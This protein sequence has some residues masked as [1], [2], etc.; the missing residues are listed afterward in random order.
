MN[1]SETKVRDLFVAGGTLEADHPTYV[2]R[3]ADAQLYQLAKAGKFA[4]VLT[5]RQ[6]GK[7]S[8]MN[9]IAHRLKGESIRTA[10]IDLNSFGTVTEETWYIQL[11]TEL[12]RQLHLNEFDPSAWWS[13][14]AQLGPVQQFN[15]FL[16]DIVLNQISEQVVVFIDEIDHTLKL[17]NFTD[18]F[19]SAI[20][21]VYNRRAVEPL[22]KRLN[23]ILLGTASPSE[24][25]ADTKQTPFNI[26]EAVVLQ[27]FRTDEAR[28][29]QT[30]LGLHLP[31]QSKEI[32]DRVYYWTD[33]HPYLTQKLCQ[34]ITKSSN[35]EWTNESV[36]ELV[37]NLFL[38][39]TAQSESNL[40]DVR[41]RI[42]KNSHFR[43][44]L[45]IYREVYDER[46]V[47]EKKQSV[48]QNQLKLSGLVKTQG[49]YLK[50][51]N[52]I[53]HHVFD[54][55]WIK[56]NVQI[57]WPQVSAFL[58]AIIALLAVS[59]I[60]Y[61]TWISNRI[62]RSVNRLYD[63][64]SP[65]EQKVA[66]LATLFR[67]RQLI[68]Q[69]K[70]DDKALELLYGRTRDELLEI[71]DHPDMKNRADLLIVIKGISGTLADVDESGHT[72]EVLNTIRLSLSH[73]QNSEQAHKKQPPF[74]Q[75]F[76]Y[77]YDEVKTLNDI[78]IEIQ[79]W[80]DGRQLARE[81]RF[82]EAQEAYN[83]AIDINPNNS[84]TRYERARILIQLNQYDDVLNDLDRVVTMARS[85]PT[86]T[87]LPEHTPTS[88]ATPEASKSAISNNSL[89]QTSTSV[90]SPTVIANSTPT[91]TNT[92]N[93]VDKLAT[94]VAK[95]TITVPSRFTAVATSTPTPTPTFTSI[96]APTST[97]TSAPTSTPTPDTFHTG[98]VTVNEKIRAA[99]ELIQIDSDLIIYFQNSQSESYP[100]LASAIIIPTAA[101]SVASSQDGLPPSSMPFGDLLSESFDSQTIVAKR[102]EIVVLSIASMLSW[103]GYSEALSSVNNSHP[104]IETENITPDIVD[105]L[106]SGFQS[107]EEII[108]DSSTQLQQSSEAPK[109][110]PNSAGILPKIEKVKTG[111]LYLQQLAIRSPQVEALEAAR[112]LLSEG[113]IL[114]KSQR[115]DDARAKWAEAAMKFKEAENS[116]GRAD[117]YL[118]IADS[119]QTEAIFNTKKLEE[120]LGYYLLATTSAT[121]SYESII[122]RELPFDAD[123]LKQATET[124][125]EGERLR[126]A[127]N[128]TQ[129][130]RKLEEARRLF[131]QIEFG[132]GEARS[133]AF[134]AVCQIDNDDFF[135]GLTT[136]LDALLITQNLPLGSS[137]MERFLEGKRAYQRGN[138]TEA[139][140]IFTEILD[141]YQQMGREDIAAQVM[142][143]MGVAYAELGRFAEAKK[144]FETALPIF[145]E[146]ENDYD[147][148]NEAVTRHNLANFATIEGAFDVAAI[149][150][151]KAIQLWWFVGE[152]SH[153]VHSLSGL[154]L[155]YTGQAQYQAAFDALDHADALYQSIP[156]AP[157]L[158]GD[159][160]NNRGMI[161]FFL[162]EYKEALD[163][164]EQAL[165][166]RSQIRG[167][168]R[169]IKEAE[170]LSN[171]ASL[172]AI[173]GNFDDA[174]QTYERMLRQVDDRFSALA[175]AQIEVNIGNIY[176]RKGNLQKGFLHF[177][178]AQELSHGSPPIFNAILLHNL[179]LTY[180]IIGEFALSLDNLT[181][182]E[183]LFEESE[184]WANIAAVNNDLGQLLFRLTRYEAAQAG[185]ENSQRV[186]QT[187]GNETEVAKVKRNKALLALVQ[188]DLT[189]AEKLI[190][191][192]MAQ[193]GDAELH[194]EEGKGTILLALVSLVRRDYE[195][196]FSHAEKAKTIAE[197]VDNELFKIISHTTIASIHMLTSDLVTANNEID[198]AII[199]LDN[200]QKAL[201]A[202]SLKSSVLEQ[203]KDIYSIAL[204]ITLLEDKSDEGFVLTEKMRDIMFLYQ[205]A[206]PWT[207]FRNDEALP[208]LL[209][210]ERAL[211][212]Q[213]RLLQNTLADELSA[214]EAQQNISLIEHLNK[215]LE[216]VDHQLEQ[217]RTEL[218][219][220]N[221]L[222]NSLIV[223][224]TVSIDDVQASLLDTETTLIAYYILDNSVQ[225]WMVD[226]EST[227]HISLDLSA[228]ELDSDINNLR[229]LIADMAGEDDEEEIAEDLAYMQERVSGPL[230]DTLIAPLEPYL[231]NDHLLIIPHKSLHY[232]PFA[233]L[234]NSN[235]ERFLSEDYMIRYA[236]SASALQFLQ[237]S[238][239]ESDTLPLVLGNPGSDLDF[240]D[241]EASAIAQ[242]YG[243]E[244]LLNQAATENSLHQNAT[245]SDILHIAAHGIYNP[246]NPMYSHLELAADDNHDGRLEAH[247]IYGLNLSD[248]KLVVL[249]ACDT[250][251]VELT[252]GDAVLSL[253]RAFLAAGAPAV[254][255]SLWP[256][257]D[258]ATSVF[259][260][261]FHEQLQN[262]TS[263]TKALQIAQQTV[264]AEE[265]WSSPYY[266]AAF[267]L[268]GADIE[269][270]K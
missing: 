251:Q 267:S 135:G 86:S 38:V 168:Q 9:R 200:W 238:P 104:W 73:I 155:A 108:R 25:I 250:S 205:L 113:D 231:E 57:N 144:Q 194:I 130:I 138:L 59:A 202:P 184:S 203:L 266:W 213:S 54:R 69:T 254:V 173:Q 244:A 19:F 241:D 26:G 181:Q 252:G 82:E 5:S 178:Q 11:V 116:L 227:H 107:M 152:P 190:I 187:L 151:E 257:D 228:E 248:A 223:P 28:N 169:I 246:I 149:E 60:A 210:K 51:R 52:P 55:N 245:D 234:W 159:L 171:I 67:S 17:A 118:R 87:P 49:D 102:E 35:V 83:Q 58:F 170:T 207:D 64:N 131:A 127:G 243:V 125:D 31:T 128:C 65:V 70:F 89:H 175:Q 249:S 56:K 91:T 258:E 109:P 8:L 126:K 40:A 163:L 92:P 20:R 29:L 189:Q 212:E 14:Q 71:F 50:V 94:D 182:A 226:Q 198:A 264:M 48:E 62:D 117:A 185:F 230:F 66:D 101:A 122:V 43:R 81:D 211:T 192:A 153:R 247:E 27:D 180:A 206:N 217:A 239:G 235:E 177:L 140:E 174:L 262:G 261:T 79:H 34:E 145:I 167:P 80:L 78:N 3:D 216:V 132:S 214:S 263:A 199:Q 237:T 147:K 110:T 22:F 42:L 162:G 195:K 32:F 44:L 61:D 96:P 88:T 242:V 121:D 142:L 114:E 74:R 6:M 220:S 172:Y 139:I 68:S 166:A 129:A 236:P 146:L 111:S 10:I 186:W 253:N 120:A 191:E 268:T 148:Y 141:A 134:K 193:F 97:P 1:N 265:Q 72:D 255:T 219:L 137:E 16:R 215:E 256:V 112:T 160:L 63:K 4:Y 47:K 93:T 188:G 30:Q 209:A 106:T 225:V 2:T 154:A 183:R 7:S 24:L 164:F 90:A 124:Y 115:P 161:H 136:L 156:P 23:F 76:R 221:P 260:Q 75:V 98:F 18:D 85:N 201:T 240:A 232:L 179:G 270:E 133:L 222:Y 77:W 165:S 229:L 36:D 12:S 21:A 123:I 45:G 103:F 46:K 41:D 13:Q 53:Y 196:A 143:D 259:M 95:R 204:Q 99:Q 197:S 37:E 150:Y 33:G 208:S 269:F 157:N 158:A 218:Q 233:A 176:V 39:E 84:A 119:L 15:S 100:S 105:S 224:D